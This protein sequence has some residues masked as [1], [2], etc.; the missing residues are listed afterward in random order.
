M[1]NDKWN[2]VLSHAIG[3]INYAP[4]KDTIYDDSPAKR[5]LGESL[6]LNNVNL[7][8]TYFDQISDVFPA[9]DERAKEARKA[10]NA[11]K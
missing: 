2:L 6:L 1:S 7:I 11:T 10:T 9:A 4:Y 3:S 8:G 5:F